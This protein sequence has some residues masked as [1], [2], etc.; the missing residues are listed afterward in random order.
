MIM[1][2]NYSQNGL[3]LYATI[4]KQGNFDRANLRRFLNI[5]FAFGNDTE[6]TLIPSAMCKK[7]LFNY[8]E[9]LLN[10]YE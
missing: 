5:S 2:Q 7:D 10:I 1:P 4:E 9:E 3:S 6:R 8:N